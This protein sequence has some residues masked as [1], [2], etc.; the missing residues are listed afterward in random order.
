MTVGTIGLW[1]LS[2]RGPYHGNRTVR[3]IGMW[4][5][6]QKYDCGPYRTVGTIARYLTLTQK[7]DC[8]HHRIVGTIAGDLTL[9]QT[10]DCGRYRNVGTLAEIRL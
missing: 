6:R 9:S 2:E 1:G 10:Y 3:I 5:P 8:G 7:R 4:T